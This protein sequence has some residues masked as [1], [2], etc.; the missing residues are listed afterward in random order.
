MARFDEV[1]GDPAGERVEVGLAAFGR[2]GARVADAGVDRCLRPL[3]WCPGDSLAK[4]VESPGRWTCRCPT[5]SAGGRGAARGVASGWSRARRHGRRRRRRSRGRHLRRTSSASERNIWREPRRKF[6]EDLS[7]VVSAVAVD[8]DKTCGRCS[9]PGL[10][11]TSDRRIVCV[12]G[13]RLDAERNVALP[14]LHAEG[15]ARQHGDL[16]RRRP[17][18]A[19][20]P[21]P[22]SLRSRSGR[23]RRASGSR[24]PRS[25]PTAT[26]RRRI[27]SA[28]TSRQFVSAISHGRGA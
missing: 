12:D 24:A 18:P 21:R 20:R 22:R 16:S 4:R 17:T 14:G 23:S 15:D 6:A 2:G 25:R 13:L 8:E 7:E 1:V 10:V 5:R 3:A 11:R 26:R 9:K 28:A 27:A 19:G